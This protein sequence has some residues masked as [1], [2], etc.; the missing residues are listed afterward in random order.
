MPAW[1]NTA[2]RGRTLMSPWAARPDAYR[3]WLRQLVAPVGLRERTSRSRSSSSTRGTSGRR[4]RISSP[5]TAS[6][7]PGSRRRSRRSGATSLARRVRSAEAPPRTEPEVLGHHQAEGQRQVATIDESCSERAS[8]GRL[9]DASLEDA[10][11]VHD[12]LDELTPAR[13]KL[14]L[15][16][17]R[18]ARARRGSTPERDRAVLLTEGDEREPESA[19]RRLRLVRRDPFGPRKYKP[20]WNMPCGND[21]SRISHHVTRLTPSSHMRYS[22]SDTQRACSRRANPLGSVGRVSQLNSVTQKRSFCLV[23]T[24]PTRAAASSTWRISPRSP[25]DTSFGSKA[26]WVGPPYVYG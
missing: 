5:T 8:A 9:V 12:R 2:R 22:A 20:D 21:S 24:C 1:D 4:A 15:H 26:R 18:L 17:H 3:R 19:Q 16:D 7:E 6:V 10:V 23:W 11:P 13:A 14:L 25:I